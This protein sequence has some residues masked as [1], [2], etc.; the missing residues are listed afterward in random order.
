MNPQIYMYNGIR[1][2]LL[3]KH[4]FFVSEVTKRIFGQFSNIEEEAKNFADAE[5][6]RLGFHLEDASEGAEIAFSKAEEFYSLLNDMHSQMILAALAALYHQWEKDLSNFIERELV[7][8]YER[9]PVNQA[10]WNSNKNDILELLKK[11]GWDVKSSSTL[12]S[13]I[14]ECRLIVNV[15]KHGDGISFKNLAN[16]YPKYFLRSFPEKILPWRSDN[17]VNYKDLLVSEEQ[18]TELANGLRNFW[19]QFPERLFLKLPS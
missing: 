12:F 2:V 10:C 11:F 15:Y 7:H 1:E 9:K 8:Y 5:Y 14:D 4:D 17:S 16:T 13:Q 3:K 18:F 19:L 6:E